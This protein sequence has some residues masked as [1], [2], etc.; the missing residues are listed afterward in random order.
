MADLITSEYAQGYLALS[1]AQLAA[2]PGA[3][4]AASRQVRNY[5]GRYLSRRPSADSALGPI[6]EVIAP[7]NRGPILLREYP[8]N[9][10]LRV[11]GS[12]T[13]ALSI[14]NDGPAVQ[15]AGAMLVRSGSEEAGFATTGLRLDRVASGVKVT[16]LITFADLA[17][18]TL[19]ALAQAVNAL[20]NGWSATVEDDFGLWGVDELGGGQGMLPA[21]ATDA[22]FEVWAE[23][24]GFR[25]I[26]DRAGILAVEPSDQADPFNSQRWGSMASLEQGDDQIRRSPIRVVYDAGYEPIPDDLRQA[27]AEV[28][29][30]ILERFGSSSTVLMERIDT[31]AI[32]Y[33]DAFDG[34]PRSARETLAFYRDHAR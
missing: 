3:I 25:R 5:C 7:E 30:A 31:W 12:P 8:I 32:T 18:P 11:S 2:L 28:A 17:G 16:D 24:L 1:T 20:G 34:L 15:R 19:A 21:R 4:A 14:R 29:K 26:D 23:D 22:R 6:D 13:V 9:E 33:R 27:V 10:I